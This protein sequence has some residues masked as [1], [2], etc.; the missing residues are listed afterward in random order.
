MERR[1]RE[2]DRTRILENQS[3]FYSS[4]IRSD[5]KSFLTE[6]SMRVDCGMKN[7]YNNL[8]EK[9]SLIHI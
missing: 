1:E 8:L 3:N 5:F 7:K 6:T 2:L 4:K 9:L